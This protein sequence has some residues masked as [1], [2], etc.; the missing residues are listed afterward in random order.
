MLDTPY[1]GILYIESWLRG[2][3]CVPLYNLMEDAAT[4]EIS[5]AQI[6]QWIKHGAQLE[7]GRK[8]DQSL[9][10]KILQEETA[11]IRTQFIQSDN[12]LDDAIEL[13]VEVS[14]SDNF[15]EFLTLPAYELLIIRDSEAKL[16]RGDEQ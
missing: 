8:I 10:N 2:Q 12:C 11:I 7:D 13:F 3:G 6:W 16:E 14:T 5:R 9:F 4:A 15:I 1:V